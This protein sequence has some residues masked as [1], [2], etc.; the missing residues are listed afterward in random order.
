MSG[1][2]VTPQPFALAG[3]PPAQAELLWQWRYTGTGI[4]ACGTLTTTA[5]TNADG[6]YLISGITG[7][8][9]GE[10]IAGLEP[11]GDAIP[12]NS[13]YPVDNL[14]SRGGQL[15]VAGFGYATAAGNYANPYY[16]N[17]LRPAVDQEV[18]TQPA[19]SGFSEVPIA[20]RAERVPGVT[21]ATAA[22]GVPGDMLSLHVIQAPRSGT[23][24]LYGM[25]VQYV[26]GTRAHSQLETF[27]FDLQDRHGKAT[28]VVTVIA[29]GD[30][31][32]TVTGAASGH[33]NVSLGNGN[34]VVTLAGSDNAVTLGSGFDVV[35]GGRDDAIN[36]AGNATLAIHGTDEM[37][38]AGKGNVTIKDFSTGLRLDIGPASG[39]D[40]MTGFLSDPSAVIGLAGG[41]GEY[42]DTAAVLSALKDDGH[43]GTLL[44]L[45]GNGWLD[46]VGVAPSQL[47][48]AN[49]QI[50]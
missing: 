27:S 4:A 17:Y 47:H 34:D 19:S 32:R 28:P 5:T 50:G 6:N 12:G 3:P 16:A 26:P 42:T 31:S 1:I 23:L 37:V 35:N 30:G 25:T 22:P 43:S 38:F 7:S 48:D 21:V 40:V 24:S 13:G 44:P 20:F 2:S 29:A 10:A 15:T 41:V 33:T 49:F 46:L 18:F 45:G 39:H 11:A 8:R 14:I 9:N 36:L